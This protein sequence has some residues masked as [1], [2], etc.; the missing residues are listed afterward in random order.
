MSYVFFWC[1]DQEC[2][3]D[4]QGVKRVERGIKKKKKDE[5]LQQA[6]ELSKTFVQTRSLLI[7]AAVVLKELY[8][9]DGSVRGYNKYLM[10]NALY[11]V[12]CIKHGFV[13]SHTA[14]AGE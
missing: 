10:V 14:V 8:R 3:F 11:A 2:L 12:S 4:T 6:N 13:T 7:I 5:A 9:G 1:S